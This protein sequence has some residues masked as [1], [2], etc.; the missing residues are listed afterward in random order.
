MS[1]LLHP[2]LHW[3]KNE[4]PVN[5][6]GERLQHAEGTSQPLRP[7]RNEP[8]PRGAKVHGRRPIDQNEAAARFIA[9]PE[10]AKMH[11]ERLWDLRKKRDAQMHGIPEWEDLRELASQIKQHTL[12]HLDRYL[13]QFEENAKANGVHVHWAVDGAAHNQIVHGI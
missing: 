13:E 6:D 10:H 3:G 11:D 2:D 8:Q 5:Q 7:N 12:G 9:A 4:A 1:K